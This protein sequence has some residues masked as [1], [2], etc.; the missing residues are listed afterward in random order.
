MRGGVPGDPAAAVY[1][2]RTEV[3]IP[4]PEEYFPPP[5]LVFTI[6]VME[7]QPGTG[8][9][10]DHYLDFI[11]PSGAGCPVPPPFL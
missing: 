6:G 1:G 2:G 9:L 10:T 8:G 11:C 3:A 4:I 7:G 5:P